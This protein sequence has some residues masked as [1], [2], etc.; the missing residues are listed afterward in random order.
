MLTLITCLKIAIS[1]NKE[2]IFKDILANSSLREKVIRDSNMN[3]DKKN[4]KLLGR[5]RHSA[6][7]AIK[8]MN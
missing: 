5:K 6:K 8:Y 3:T 2:I 1:E 7:E 4:S